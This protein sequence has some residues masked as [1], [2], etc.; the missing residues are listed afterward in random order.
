MNKRFKLLFKRVKDGER[1]QNLNLFFSQY[2]SDKDNLLTEEEIKYFKTKLDSKELYVDNKII[3]AKAFFE[4]YRNTKKYNHS[5]KYLSLMNKLAFEIDKFD[6]NKEEIFFK[7]LKEDVKYPNFK[8]S[9]SSVIPIF[10]CGMPRSGT[11]LCEQ[12]LSAHSDVYGAGE[13]RYLMQLTNIENSGQSDE[14]YLNEYFKNIKDSEFLLQIRN[15][16]LKIIQNINLNK[17]GHVCD[18][19]PH[20]FLMIDLIRNILPEAKIIYCKRKPEDNCFSLLT[21]RFVESR[22][23]Y[24]YDQKTLAEYYLLHEDLMKVWL[25]K[26]KN[27]IFV[28]DNEDLVGNQKKVTQDLLNFCNLK[29]EKECMEYYKTKRQVRTASLEQVR[30]PINRSSIGAWQNYKDNLHEMLNVLNSHD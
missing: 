11:T 27:E 3:L 23:Q 26:Y 30:Q 4:Y 8:M 18:K 5:Y 17:H 7:K 10:I 9:K 24:C 25:H 2:A 28:L 16:Y 1:V 19:M 12:I 22:H 6:L 15:D 20:N 14:K 13:L 29:W 21:Q